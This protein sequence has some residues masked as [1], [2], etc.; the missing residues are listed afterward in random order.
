MRLNDGIASFH[1]ARTGMEGALAGT[2]IDRRLLTKALPSVLRSIIPQ[3]PKGAA[4][5]RSARDNVLQ[6]MMLAAAAHNVA[7]SSARPHVGPHAV[8]IVD[9]A[10]QCRGPR[11]LQSA[12]PHPLH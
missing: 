2:H 6:G 7:A 10:G 8:F 12:P 1:A 5:E 3:P 11:A 9:R 4:A